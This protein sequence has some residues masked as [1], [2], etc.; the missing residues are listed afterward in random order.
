M[1]PCAHRGLWDALFLTACDRW[2]EDKVSNTTS[3][4]AWELGY[5]F[6]RG[7]QNSKKPLFEGLCAMCGCL[8]YIGANSL[9][10]FCF[11]PNAGAAELLALPRVTRAPSACDA[12][13]QDR[14]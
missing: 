13:A 9:G 3:F 4:D 5:W 8:L 12:S 6:H 7:Q 10:N 11:G 14:Q 1:P 2:T